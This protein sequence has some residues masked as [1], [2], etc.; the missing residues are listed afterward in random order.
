MIGLP[1]RIGFAI[2]SVGLRIFDFLIDILF[3]L[4]IFINFNTSY[5]A[6][7]ENTSDDM[8][9]TNRCKVAEAYL[10]SWFFVDLLATVPFDSIVKLAVGG[11]MYAKRYLSYTYP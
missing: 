3:V 7:P 10:K 9:E 5:D 6:T 8:L 11:G 4:D 2:D 1:L